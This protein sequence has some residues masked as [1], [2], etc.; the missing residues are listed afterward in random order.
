MAPS[1][2]HFSI[3]F[4]CALVHTCFHLL[5]PFGGDGNA[6]DEDEDVVSIDTT[7]R[8]ETVISD[9]S[10]AGSGEAS[11]FCRTCLRSKLT[12]GEAVCVI[13]FALDRF[14]EETR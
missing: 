9:W 10:S 11:S 6:V 1:N 4:C 8:G 3:V 7:G 12:I 5:V 14:L 13:M 2:I